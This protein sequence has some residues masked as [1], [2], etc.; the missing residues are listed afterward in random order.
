[1]GC[2]LHRSRDGAHID[3]RA[4]LRIPTMGELWVLRFL[5]GRWQGDRANF[6]TL[7]EAQARKDRYHPVRKY[8]KSLY[9]DRT[10]RLKHWLY[11]HC[12]TE[13]TALNCWF[14]A[15]ILMGAVHRVMDPGAKFDLMLVLEGKQGVGKSSIASILGGEWF[16]DGVRLGDDPKV[17]IEQTA[18]KWIIE[19]PE[20]SGMSNKEVECIKAQISRTHDR[21][22]LAYARLSSDVPRQ[23]VLI[24][25]TNDDKYLKDKSGNRRFMPVRVGKIDLDALKFERDQLWAEAYWRYCQGMPANPVPEMLWEEAG[26][27][28]AARVLDDPVEDYL[29]E[30]FQDQSGIVEKDEIRT[31]LAEK[32]F[33]PSHALDNTVHKLMAKLQW[34]PSRQKG[35]QKVCRWQA[36]CLAD[37]GRIQTSFRAVRPS[38]RGHHQATLTRNVERDPERWRP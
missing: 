29:I 34:L 35:L 20:L 5:T 18:G 37:L 13:K 36:R 23:F 6:A 15:A 1:M 8:L 30:W 17:M 22:R 12:N 24:G 32:R 33:K 16:G 26:E 38:G 2:C 11:Q 10:P 3:G 27:A 9:W 28:Q 7:I 4:W 14:G 19:V 25:T 21:A 31:V